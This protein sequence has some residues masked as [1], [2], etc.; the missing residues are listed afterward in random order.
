MER[1]TQLVKDNRYYIAEILRDLFGGFVVVLR[2]G[3]MKTEWER[4]I[5]TADVLAQVTA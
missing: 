4:N 1:L 2:W 3:S 5:H